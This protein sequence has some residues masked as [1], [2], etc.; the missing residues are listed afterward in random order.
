MPQTP[1][2]KMNIPMCAA[3]VLLC[4]TLFSMYL[5]GGLYSKYVGR[6][7]SGD[8]ARVAK[9]SVS[10]SPST[11]ADI[12]I[13]VSAGTGKKSGTYEFKLNNASEVAVKYGVLLTFT[14]DVP[15]YLSVTLNGAAGTKPGGADNKLLF[16]NAGTSAPNGAA[17]GN[18]LAFS[19]SS[20]DGFS[21]G[22]DAGDHKIVLD[23]SASVM[24]EQ[25]D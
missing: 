5:T 25:I 9:F 7:D 1:K 23:F 22:A 4:L 20:L 15:D 12:N 17:A 13:D 3:C 18:T 11:A 10:I 2:A 24:C 16:E 8:S 19:V 14:E 6:D 21:S